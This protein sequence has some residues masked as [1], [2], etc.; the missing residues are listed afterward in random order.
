VT[1]NVDELA[2]QLADVAAIEEQL[3][4][5]LDEILAARRALDRPL[6]DRLDGLLHGHAATALQVIDQLARVDVMTLL[7]AMGRAGTAAVAR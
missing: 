5:L 2:Q 3:R 7:A 4:G 6:L 1:T